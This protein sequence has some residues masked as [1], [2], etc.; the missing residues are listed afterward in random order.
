MKTSHKSSSP[1]HH[2][3]NGK[4]EAAVKIKLIT[5]CMWDGNDQAQALLELRNTLTSKDKG[6]ETKARDWRYK[7][8]NMINIRPFI[9]TNAEEQQAEPS[10]EQ[11][12]YRW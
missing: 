11:R 12:Q 1:W 8:R 6:N 2:S 3:G 9:K 4:T 5:N 7:N 10:S